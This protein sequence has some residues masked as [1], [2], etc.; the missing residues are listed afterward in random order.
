ML[1]EVA[2]LAPQAT[3]RNR[4]RMAFPE[5]KASEQHV[6]RLNAWMHARLPLPCLQQPHAGM[7]MALLKLGDGECC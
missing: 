3:C 4:T 7:A 2:V 6:G 5:G 1:T